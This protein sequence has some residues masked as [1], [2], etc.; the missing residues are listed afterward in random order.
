VGIASSGERDLFGVGHLTLISMEVLGLTLLSAQFYKNRLIGFAIL[1]GCAIDFGLGVYL[2]AR[3][4]HLDNTEAHTYYTGLGIKNGQ[5]QVGMFGPDSVGQISWR[6]WLNKR[7]P[8]LGNEWLKAAAQ[9]HPGDARLEAS[10]AAFRTAMT[11]KLGEDEKYWYGWFA[12]H[13]GETVYLGDWLGDSD[14]PSAL[15]V[16][17]AAGL[18]WMLAKPEPVRAAN[19][20]SAVKA[21]AA[22]ARRKRS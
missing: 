7:Q 10:R 4:E 22:P 12:R 11:E 14:V 5:F 2:H 20:V 17:A 19:T 18:L 3:V 8:I 16:I 1:A 6:N 15:L 21:K 9:Y 13:G